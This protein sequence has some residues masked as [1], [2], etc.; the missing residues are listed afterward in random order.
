[1]ASPTGMV[2]GRRALAAVCAAMVASAGLGWGA[3]MQIRSP[4]Q[5]ALQGDE[6]E[7]SLIT[8]AVE[9]RVLTSTVVLRGTVRYDEP[10]EVKLTGA[11]AIEG[12]AVVTAV[13]DVGAELGEGQ[14]A[15]QVSGRPL[16]V[17]QGDLPAYRNLGPGS[18][19]DDVRQ[20]EEALA[21]LGHE[22]GPVDGLYDGQTG[23]AVDRWYRANGFDAHGPSPEQR[24]AL[25]AAEAHVAA[26]VD[27]VAQAEQ[28]LR[29]AGTPPT[30]S[31]VIAAE[32]AVRAARDGLASAEAAAVEAQAEAAATAAR[33]VAARDLAATAARSSAQ[34]R[35]QGR[36]GE[37]PDTGAPPTA[38]EQAQL[39]EAARNADSA[40]QAAESE[41]V[42][43]EAAKARVAQEGQAAIRQARDQVA[44]AEAQLREATTP[45]STQAE[46]AALAAARRQLTEARAELAALQ[47]GL[48]VALP[49]AE[50]AFVPRLPAR[51]DEVK[52]QR[53]ETP[54]GALL[55]LTGARLAI[56]ATVAAADVGLLAVA[57]E[58]LIEHPHSGAVLAGQITRIADQPAG[59]GTD[60]Q[61][62]AVEITPTDPIEDLL[63]AAV[64]ITV[65]VSSTGGEVLAVPL[66]ALSAN[67]AGQARVEVAGPAGG[68]R[69]VVVSTGLS[70]GGYVEVSPA[71]DDELAVG[72]RVVVGR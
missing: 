59:G 18:E 25:A 55:V 21:R 49:A 24:T 11:P 60:A 62:H 54:T 22:P 13:P 65:P 52:A 40:L 3:A 66:A 23:A 63:D 16:L 48:G 64:K 72:D 2:R 30:G 51:V 31:A 29:Q 50:V 36:A 53:G 32:A 61:R 20:L 19:G 4:A 35:D 33:A 68:V 46:Q 5:A 39:E 37:H 44:I 47:A 8:A 7:P 28:A 12:A 58:V 10:F 15:A 67:A 34:R 41:V 45:G 43:T 69:T 1:M 70:A 56:D 57:A 9:R 17:L 38:E 26:A 14:V 27:G 42:R 6:P 71:A